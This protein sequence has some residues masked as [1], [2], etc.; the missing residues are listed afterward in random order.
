MSTLLT[1]ALLN[2]DPATGMVRAPDKGLDNLILNSATLFT[3]LVD[4]EEK[5]SWQSQCQEFLRK[6]QLELGC[7]ARSPGH[8]GPNSVDNLIAAM[9]VGAPMQRFDIYQRGVR[10]FWYYRSTELF[11]FADW[12]GRFLGFPTSMRRM[13]GRQL[14]WGDKLRWKLSA[15]WTIRTPREQTSDKCLLVLMIR[16]EAEIW[17]WNDKLILWALARLEQAYPLGLRELYGIYFGKAHPF[18]DAAPAHW[19]LWE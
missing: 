17:G 3:L 13:L 8:A 10:C 11:N 15:W 19:R 9:V 6:C 1:R 14:K 5:L 7:F 12:Y 2:R 4:H 18:T 16:R